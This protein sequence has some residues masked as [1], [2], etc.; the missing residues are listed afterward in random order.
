[1]ASS[2]VDQQNLHMLRQALEGTQEPR[3]WAP[4][5]G[6]LEASILQQKERVEG[7]GKAE[8]TSSQAGEAVNMN[9]TPRPE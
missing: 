1:M 2:C 5:Q 8:L 9:V 4:I 6:C 3:L 7:M